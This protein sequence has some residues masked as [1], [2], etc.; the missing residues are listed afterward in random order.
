[1]K[2]SPSR[3]TEQ[4]KQRLNWMPWLF[5]RLKPEQRSWA[6]AWQAE[7]QDWL[8][9]AETISFAENCFVAADAALFAEPNRPI[10]IGRGSAIASQSFLHGPITCG[11][12]V[13]INHRC[14]LDG[15]S[16]G[17][18]IGAHSRIAHS[19]SIYAFNHGM[20]SNRPIWK[21]ATSSKGISIGEDVWIGARSCITDGVNIGCHAVVGM[22]AVVTR[23]IPA[24][25]IVAGNPAR[26][27]GDRRDKGE[28]YLQEF[29]GLE[30]SSL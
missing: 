9:E 29:T 26:V 30:E 28:D 14:S 19:C 7:I 2:Q 15:G 8:S 25:A 1:M 3:F 4:H 10:S 12:H 20:R 18:S 27:I 23:D 17:I 5:F 16:Q 6:E 21:Q 24:W 11:E 22:G 13:F